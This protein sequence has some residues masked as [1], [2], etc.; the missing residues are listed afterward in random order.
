MEIN[1]G[2]MAYVPEHWGLSRSRIHCVEK[3]EATEDLLICV[4]GLRKFRIGCW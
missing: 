3:S 4:A 1:S 2:W